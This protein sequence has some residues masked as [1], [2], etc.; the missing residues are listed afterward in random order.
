MAQPLAAGNLVGRTRVT[1]NILE[2][3]AS[4]NVETHKIS[5][6]PCPPKE[7]NITSFM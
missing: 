2:E 7:C 6:F 1:P 4:N 3:F 5:L